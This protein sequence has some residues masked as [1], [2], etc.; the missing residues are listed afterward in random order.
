MTTI[1]GEITEVMESWPLQLVVMTQAGSYDIALEA[2]TSV[3]RA[4][5]A[6]TANDLSP[7][8]QV[9]ITG[10]TSEPGQGLIAHTIDML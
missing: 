1:T 8:Q 9:R 2:E 6:A 7:G 10:V 4:G 5:Q 3:T